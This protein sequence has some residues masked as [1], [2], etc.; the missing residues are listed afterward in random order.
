MSAAQPVLAGAEM[1]LMAGRPQEALAQLATLPTSDAIGA[2]AVRLRCHALIQLERWPEAAAAARAGLA[3]GGPDP[4]LLRLLGRAE[5]EL[6]NLQVAER[7]LLDGLAL[8][9]HD[10][11]LLCTYAQLCA[12]SNQVDKAEKLVQR[13]A[14]EQPHAPIV[15]ATRVQVAY[16][17]GDD[18]AAQ[19]ISREFIAEHPE[20]PAAHALLGGMSAVR[21]QVG[22][23]YDG[24]RQA[25][26]SA[27]GEQAWAEGAMEMRIAKHPLMLPIRPIL[28]F[29]PFRTWAVAVALIFGLR[30]VAPPLSFV[31]AL[32]WA[33]LCVYS[34]IV[35]PLVRRWV[36]RNWG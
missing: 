26:A 35:P 31:V 25:A 30:Q 21:G 5:R 34:W 24:L 19:R 11:E 2:E 16:A 28:R 6:G 8:A 13:A 15:Y 17:R 23:A 3:A 14:A 9:P 22:P 12:A 1:L 32:A 10:V 36:R 4:D 7:A 27:P 20:N 33:A 18:K 29:G